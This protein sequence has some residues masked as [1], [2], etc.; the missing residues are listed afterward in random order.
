VKKNLLKSM[1]GIVLLGAAGAASADIVT[2]TYAGTVSNGEDFTGVFYPGQTAVSF[3]NYHP[4]YTLVFTFNTTVGSL[5]T[6]SN[7]QEL[8]GGSSQ[9]AIASPGS[10]VLTIN[11]VSVSSDGAYLGKDYAYGIGVSTSGMEQASSS[12]YG[13]GGVPIATFE[14]GTVSTDNTRWP[15]SITKNGTYTI[16][17]SEI[18]GPAYC[19]FFAINNGDFVYNASGELAPTTVTV[20]DISAVPL[21]A[22]AWLLLSGLAGMGAMVRR[23]LTPA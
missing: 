20:S 19:N 9:G 3:T 6:T 22:A 23:R 8:I 1:V 18:C 7:A 14:G 13:L 16:A 17:P 4:A 12:T 11:G 21:P 15:V 10:A 5:T 2:V